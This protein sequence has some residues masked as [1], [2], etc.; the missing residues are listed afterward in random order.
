MRRVCVWRVSI[1]IVADFEPTR[2]YPLC[3]CPSQR[4]VVSG[5]VQGEVRVWELR[6]RELVSHLK[7]HTMPVTDV[8]LFPDD[9]HALSCSRDRS[10]L[11]WDLRTERRISSHTQRMGG[12][13]AV[14]VSEGP[15]G[16]SIYTVGQEQKVT[17]WDLRMPSAVRV[18]GKSAHDHVNCEP[19]EHVN[20]RG[21]RYMVL[22]RDGESCLSLA[23]GPYLCVRVYPIVYPRPL[24]RHLTPRRT[25][26]HTHT[27]THTQHILFHSR[28]RSSRLIP[29]HSPQ[30]R[31]KKSGRFLCRVTAD[32]LRRA[33]WRKRSSCGTP[34]RWS[35]GRS[36][37]ASGIPLASKACA[38]RRTI[39]RSRAWATTPTS[40]FGTYFLRGNRREGGVTLQT[41]L[42]DGL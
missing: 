42:F 35:A 17:Q 27:H 28:L 19:N 22:R 14:G 21:L 20:P 18:V 4:F 32:S 23:R 34:R 7:E 39:S 1:T 9:V 12:M 16:L 6:S 38:F 33:A 11:C 13:N 10:L 41:G 26:T 31:V 24:T 29:T 40:L 8:A 5:G 2:L 15:A 36:A 37:R 3:P 30:M 25:H